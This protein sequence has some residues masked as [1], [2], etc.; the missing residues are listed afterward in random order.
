MARKGLLESNQ[1]KKDLV[2]RYSDRRLKLKT[3]IMD[4]NLTLEDRW[5]AVSKI[6]KLPRSSSPVRIRNRCVL[7]GRPR[8]VYQF[9]ELSRGPLR[10]MAVKGLLPGMRRSSW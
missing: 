1:R 8:G 9:F 7:T 3:M 5:E 2:Q 6:S 10:D 4:K